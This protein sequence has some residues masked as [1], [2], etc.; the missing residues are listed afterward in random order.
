MPTNLKRWP[1]LHNKATREQGC[2]RLCAR[3]QQQRA[4]RQEGKAG[5]QRRS[6][7]KCGGLGHSGLSYGDSDP[8]QRWIAQ[9]NNSSSSAPAAGEH[10]RGDSCCSAAAATQRGRRCMGPALAPLPPSPLAHH[11]CNSSSFDWRSRS[12]P[13]A[14]HS[15]LTRRQSSRRACFTAQRS[16]WAPHSHPNRHSPAA[17]SYSRALSQPARPSSPPARAARPS[18]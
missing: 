9:V 12:L 17:P 1:L 10:D 11:S 13:T 14:P 7:P 8:L 3:S 4:R 6:A 2:F 16:C 5:G 15:R 18:S